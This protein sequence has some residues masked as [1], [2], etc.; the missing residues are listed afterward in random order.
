MGMLGEDVKHFG[1]GQIDLRRGH[2]WL[3]VT[4]KPLSAH[5]VVL[6]AA[7]G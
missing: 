7:L 3:S 6:F 2:L 1:H 5:S 4:I